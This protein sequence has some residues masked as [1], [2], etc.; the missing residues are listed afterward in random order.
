MNFLFSKF[1]YLPWTFTDGKKEA[2]KNKN[3]EGEEVENIAKNLLFFT[4]F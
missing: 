3:C 2:S 1:F 4:I